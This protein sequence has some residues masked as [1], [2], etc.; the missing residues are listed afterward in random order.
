MPTCAVVHT[1]HYNAQCTSQRRQITLLSSSLYISFIHP[2]S[3]TPRGK[4]V[5]LLSFPV[6]PVILS[7]MVVLLVGATCSIPAGFLLVELNYF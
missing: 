5:Q 2:C 1:A 6:I 7:S 4:T 3:V